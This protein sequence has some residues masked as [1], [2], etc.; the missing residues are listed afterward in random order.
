MNVKSHHDCFISYTWKDKKHVDS[1]VRDLNE[2]GFN[3]WIDREKIK[4]GERIREAIVNEIGNSFCVFLFLSSTSVKS[5]SVLNEIDL[6]M[7]REFDAKAI[8]LVPILI[9][10]LKW[11]EIPFDLR[12]K[13]CIDLRGNFAQKYE[14]NRSKLIGAV[15][16]SNPEKFPPGCLFREFS[17]DKEVFSFFANRIESNVEIDSKAV[18]SIAEVIASVIISDS[19]IFFSATDGTHDSFVKIKE[20]S[21]VKGIRDAI[22]FVIV[23]LNLM[24]DKIEITEDSLREIASFLIVLLAVLGINEKLEEA[25]VGQVVKMGLTSDR[26]IAYRLMQC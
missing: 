20:F 9:G 25:N 26:E 5:K 6:A 1:V 7:L 4:P 11:S 8:V 12:S 23:Y 21:G 13:L 22:A 19:G 15:T 24:P 3:V 2:T 16:D 10:R 14:E 17:V 18:F